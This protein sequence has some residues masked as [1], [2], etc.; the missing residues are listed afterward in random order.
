MI[1]SCPNCQKKLNVDD[2]LAGQQVKCPACQQVF[3]SSAGGAAAPEP[4]APDPGTTSPVARL[5]GLGTEGLLALGKVVLIAGLVLVVFARGCDSIGSRG[6]AR[7]KAKLDNASNKFDEKWSR[8][9]AKAG[10]F[11]ESSKLTAERDKEREK[12]QN[13]KWLDLQASARNAESSNIL[14]GYWREWVFVI[15]SVLLAMGCLAVGFYGTGPERI[16]CL[17]IIAL[18]T[19]SLYV[20]GIAWTGSFLR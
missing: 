3:A 6:V 12:L 15:G 20:V 5:G 11:S 13:G 14:W 10:S 18:I 2:A 7:A 8:K 9:L 17:V 19:F 4:G 1:V 16:V